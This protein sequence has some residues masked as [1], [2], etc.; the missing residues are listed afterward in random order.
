MGVSDFN[1]TKENYTRE[2]EEIAKA[3]INRKLIILIGAGV[4]IG[5]KMPSWTAFLE[6]VKKEISKPK[7]SVKKHWIETIDKA[8]SEHKF[9]LA[10]S[11]LEEIFPDKNVLRKFAKD[12]IDLKKENQNNI[13]ASDVIKNL[14]SIY[15]WGG[16]RILTTNYDQVVEY[17]FDYY[18]VKPK[19]NRLSPY[20]D[21]KN[22]DK[23]L[24]KVQSIV[25]RENSFILKLH[26]E[27]NPIFSEKAYSELYGNH[28]FQEILKTLFSC[29]VILFIGCSFS[30]DSLF[31]SIKGFNK[32][33]LIEAYAIIA[34]KDDSE[35]DVSEE[36]LI[37]IG[38]NPIK[39]INPEGKENIGTVYKNQL[40]KLLK[41]IVLKT[42]KLYKEKAENL[43]S[44][45]I[46]FDL[47]SAKRFFD[48]TAQA[49]KCI[50]F[51]TQIDFRQWFTPAL[52]LHLSLQKAAFRTNKL[53]HIANCMRCANTD[54][55]QQFYEKCE[56]IIPVQTQGRII[57]VPYTI[58]I[59]KDKLTKDSVMKLNIE[60]LYSIHQLTSCS[61]AIVCSDQ[62]ASIVLEQKEFFTKENLKYLGLSEEITD[63]TDIIDI[64]KDLEHD[65]KNQ[66][67]NACHDINDI[68]FAYLE[69]QI[70]K[71]E[72]I[73]I[74]TEI[75]EADIIE[76]DKDFQKLKYFT[77]ADAS[78]YS[79]EI[80][81][82]KKREQCYVEFSKIIM[83]QVF[84]KVRRQ[85]LIE[86]E[87]IA[88]V[89]NPQ[90]SF[91]RNCN[92]SSSKI[93]EKEEELIVKEVY[94]VKT[95]LK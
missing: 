74:E 26:G 55:W 92:Y 85:E 35:A 70:S 32:D 71:E 54:T 84:K 60:T 34:Q 39:L 41:E 77:S 78:L 65:I 31:N 49:Q 93:L 89:M 48:E 24:K 30:K 83:Q 21:I 2:I 50:F 86:N 7:Y 95:Y 11:I 20:D 46:D 36:L 73:N 19:L 18:K 25:R 6:N 29:N 3:I 66:N 51:N 9:V 15:N 42:E 28:T 45:R 79:K 22:D 62:L 56:N 33:N 12:L 64:I 75:W 82:T 27:N 47:V 16:D 58:N 91:Y 68:D 44:N 63:L 59:F 90:I 69:K 5:V 52:Q 80:T 38:I 57:F 87:D 88:Y 81:D 8:I 61:L 94:D 23:N 43:L 37:D 67:I 17:G 72:M 4:S 1:I 40:G 76:A 13:E 53:H 10:G 14:A